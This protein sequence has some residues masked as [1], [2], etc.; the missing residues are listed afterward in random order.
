MAAGPEE[1]VV[2]PTSSNSAE[3]DEM[4]NNEFFDYDALDSE[5]EMVSY[6]SA[7]SGCEKDQQWEQALSSSPETWSPRLV[8]TLSTPA[9]SSQWLKVSRI[10]RQTTQVEMG[11]Q[12]HVMDETQKLM[13]VQSCVIEKVLRH[14][15]KLEQ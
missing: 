6:N 7:I 1:A 3:L 10:S 5:P 12:D 13:Q 2:E 14:I 9:S 15:Q 11:R 4:T 8:E